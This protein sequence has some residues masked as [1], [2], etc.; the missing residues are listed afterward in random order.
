M[1]TEQP[2]TKRLKK[3]LVAVFPERNIH[4]SVFELSPQLL[5]TTSKRSAFMTLA[6]A[7]TKSATKRSRPSS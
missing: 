3:S 2:T 6:Q 7:A 5:A 1:K 4:V